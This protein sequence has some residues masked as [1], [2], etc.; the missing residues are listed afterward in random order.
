MVSLGGRVPVSL[1]LTTVARHDDNVGLAGEKV[2]DGSVVVAPAVLVAVEGATL[3][4]DATLSGQFVRYLERK[5]LDAD[6][7]DLSATAAYRAGRSDVRA[8]VFHRETDS[9][10]L[11]VRSFEEAQRQTRTGAEARANWEASVKTRVGLGAGFSRVTYDTVLGVDSDTW[12]FPLSVAYRVAEK[13]RSTLDY[14]HS[15]TRVRST[16]VR[17][18]AESLRLGLSGD[19]SGRLSGNLSAGFTRGSRLFGGDDDGLGLNFGLSYAVSPVTSVS[20][21]GGRQFQTTFRG[22]T[23]E[24]TTAR[25]TVRFDLDEVWGARL[26]LSWEDSEGTLS[27]AS[28]RFVV[29]EGEV[30]R[31]LTQRVTARL[32]AYVRRSSGREAALDFDSTVV[33]LS[34]A[35]RL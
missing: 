7:A 34:A 28:D 24:V 21:D 2:G 33:S 22:E 8:E 25:G 5:D 12:T 30:S 15:R 10:S 16:E 6:L 20:L 9:G 14:E 18:R 19:L 29:A 17:N 13:L 11:E 27:A 23:A 26:G 1:S 4:I 32:A 3:Q 35:I 31:I